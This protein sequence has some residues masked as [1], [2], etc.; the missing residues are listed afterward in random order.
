[1]DFNDYLRLEVEAAPSGLPNLVRNPNGQKGSWGYVTPVSNTNMTSDGTALTLT[2]T[3]TQAVH[4]TTTDVAVNA[5]Q[6][7]AARLD[8]IAGSSG[9]IRM[10]FEWYDIDKVYLSS[11]A[12]TAYSNAVGPVFLPAVIAPT[13]TAYVRLRVDW[14][15]NTSA[16]NP[17][18]GW[19]LT[20]NKVMITSAT[21]SSDIQETR[22]NLIPN[23]NFESDTLGWEP[24]NNSP[25]TIAR[26]TSTFYSG[27][28]CMSLTGATYTRVVS[29][30][31]PVVGGADYAVQAQ[32]KASVAS[33]VYVYVYTYWYNSDGNYISATGN[34]WSL[35]TSWSLITRQTTAPSNA[36]YVKVMFSLDGESA[37]DVVY[38]DNVMLEQSDTIG[39]YFDG[40]TPDGALTYTW[41]NNIT[42]TNLIE[43][44]SFETDASWWKGLTRVNS[45]TRS[46]AQAYFG[47]A[48]LDVNPTGG[49][50]FFEFRTNWKQYGMP[51]EGGK[52]YNVGFRYRLGSSVSEENYVGFDVRWYDGDNNLIST[53]SSTVTMNTPTLTWAEKTASAVAPSDAVHAALIVQVKRLDGG[54]WNNNSSHYFD[55]FYFTE[56]FDGY[57]DGSFTD[58]ANRTYA[59][60]GTANISESTLVMPTASRAIDPA[61]FTYVDPIEW[62]NIL[63]P[64]HSIEIDRQAL[65]LGTLKATVLDA[66]LD[67]A[68]SSDIAPGRAVRVRALVDGTW[69]NVYEGR[70]DNATVTYDLDKSKVAIPDGPVDRTNL[71][72][73]PSFEA[74]TSSWGVTYSGAASTFSRA[75]GDAVTGSYAAT[76]TSNAAGGTTAMGIVTTAGIPAAAEGDVF[77]IQAQ[78][79]A[80]TTGRNVQVGFYWR[81]SLGAVIAIDYSAVSPDNVD[82]FTTFTHTSTAPAGT[83]DVRAVVRINDAGIGA[84]EVHL[85]DAVILE[86]TD[87]VNPYFDGNSTNSKYIYEW[88]GTPHASASTRRRA[89]IA[90]TLITTIDL[91]ATDA[92]SVLAQQAESRGVSTIN[93][94]PYLLEDKGVAWN[95]NGSGDQIVAAVQTSYNDNAT[96]LDQVSLARDAVSGYAWVDRYN[97]LN[98]WDYDDMYSGTVTVFSDGFET[99][100]WPSVSNITNTRTSAVKRTGTYSMEMTTT[101]A[102]LS[103]VYS[104]MFAITEGTTYTA[105]MYSRA[106]TSARDV[107]VAIYWYDASGSY[108][109]MAYSGIVFRNSAVAWNEHT[110]S[111][112]APAGATQAQVYFNAQSDQVNEIHYLDDVTV[113]ATGIPDV[114][115]SDTRNAADDYDEY[116]FIDAGFNTDDVINQVNIKWL[117]YNSGT[118]NSEEITYGPYNDSASQAQYGVRQ[119]TFTLQGLFESESSIA[120]FAQAVLDSRKV[121]VRRASAITVPVRDERGIR[122]ATTVDL[123]SL[124]GVEFRDIINA[125]YRVTS[126]K[127][128]ITPQAWDVEYGF[129]VDGDVA[130]PQVTPS[131]NLKGATGTTIT[132]SVV[133][134]DQIQ[135]SN[136]IKTGRANV[137]M[138][139]AGNN[140]TKNVTFDT[141]FPSDG[142]V[143]RVILSGEGLTGNFTVKISASSID[144]N[145]FTINVVRSSGTVNVDVDWIAVAV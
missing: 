87:A 5:G 95:V 11:S 107:D 145:G 35:D 75:S 51:V 127:H 92:T 101:T 72:V 27:T 84:S 31:I 135:A 44:P 82:E 89:G 57:F 103:G 21:N 96:V 4:F 115:Y 47:T 40:D 102:A 113:K 100:A 109:G 98:A 132:G 71:C 34:S 140:F 13:N 58:T 18:A 111:G 144:R 66:L 129:G 37:G 138:G 38:V 25:V 64:T 108:L 1:M 131:P 20:F 137:V 80:V 24:Y 114:V 63:G 17:S 19:T 79:K 142:P 88:T 12:Q 15:S 117:R 2:T 112:T 118:E 39:T 26:T 124:I 76:I 46:T 61:G 73:N 6:Y 94:L 133:F 67:P 33:G 141:P 83:A 91:T 126:I 10:R 54:T 136:W 69:D 32:V 41:V 106:A 16:G 22:F 134:T 85:V 70:I 78:V 45:V 42:Y 29:G 97:V 28:A 8:R 128:T 90:P 86:K 123:Y 49:Y 48:S 36:S 65:D 56:G 110:V 125:A 3:V 93:E 81:D 30:S 68:V 9:Y 116:T 77:T 60:T 43:N 55:G 53:Y 139:T 62:K 14:Y 105:S 143:P 120:A 121:P 23:P 122:H 59:W 119:A 130:S 52:T 50:D 7:V 74:N 99:A 104:P